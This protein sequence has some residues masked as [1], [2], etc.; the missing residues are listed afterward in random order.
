M[1]AMQVCHFHGDEGV[2][3][4]PVG[5]EGALEFTCP[6]TQGHPRPGTYS[7]VSYPP[8][9]DDKLGSGLMAELGLATELPAV[10]KG[11][12]G[13]WV[14]YGVVEHDYAAANPEDFA[15][16]VDRYGHTAVAAKKYTT[17]AFLAL[18][19]GELSRRGTLLCRFGPATGRWSYNSQ[20]SYWALPPEPT[21]DERLSWADSGLDVNYVPGSTE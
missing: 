1:V 10:L 17:S 13:R 4:V 11:H 6:R 7:W 15:R 5:T 2:A 21:W 8:P 12:V 14:E 18:A 3:G 16:L 19:L 20:V 9:P